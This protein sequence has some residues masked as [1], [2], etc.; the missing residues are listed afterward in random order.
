MIHNF[1]CDY[2]CLNNDTYIK[3]F[4]MNSINLKLFLF[5]KFFIILY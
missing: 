5:Y 3:I 4:Y 1:I 2:I